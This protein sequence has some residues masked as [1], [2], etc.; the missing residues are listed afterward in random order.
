MLLAKMKVYI[1]HFIFSKKVAIIFRNIFA[2]KIGEKIDDLDSNYC[3]LGGK[4]IL[5]H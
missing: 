4:N 2:Q 1:C 5:L 3:H